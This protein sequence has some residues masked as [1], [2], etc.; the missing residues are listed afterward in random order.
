MEAYASGCGRLC[1][2]PKVTGR[3]VARL[4]SVIQSTSRAKS[5]ERPLS[6]PGAASTTPRPSSP[7]ADAIPISSSD[8]ANVPGTGCPSGV[9][10]R[11]VRDVENPSAPPAIASATIARMSAICSALAGLFSRLSAPIAQ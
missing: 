1:A 5:S 8:V 3:P 10:C 7:S 6:M 4:T 2:K 9:R 11:I